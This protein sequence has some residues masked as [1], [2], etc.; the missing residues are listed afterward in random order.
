MLK[1]V[2]CRALYPPSPQKNAEKAV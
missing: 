1:G 2:E